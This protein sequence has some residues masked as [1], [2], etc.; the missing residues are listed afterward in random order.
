MDVA[1]GI[2]VYGTRV[3][4]YSI[5]SEI[6]FFQWTGTTWINQGTGITCAGSLNIDKLGRL[7][8]IGSDGFIYAWCADPNLQGHVV[9]VGVNGSLSAGTLAAGL[10]V[11][12]CGCLLFIEDH[13][14]NLRQQS[15]FNNSWREQG[16]IAEDIGG[17]LASDEKNERIFIKGV[18]SDNNI[19][20][21]NWDYNAVNISALKKLGK[22]CEAFYNDAKKYYW[23]IEAPDA[24]MVISTES[25]QLYYT[26]RNNRLW[27]FYNDMDKG[28]EPN[29]YSTPLHASGPANGALALEPGSLGSLFYVSSQK[30]CKIDWTKADYPIDCPKM[31]LPDGP[32]AGTDPDEPR[33]AQ[34]A[35][36]KTDNT[37]TVK[38]QIQD[39]NLDLSVTVFPNPSLGTFTFNIA[40]VN[41]DMGIQLKI[42]DLNG[43]IV[44]YIQRQVKPAKHNEIKWEAAGQGGGVYFYQL[45]LNNGSIFT[46]KLIKY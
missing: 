3:Y 44:D 16:I 39:V 11:H 20:G 24:N 28:K 35:T 1:G 30:L 31:L 12:S 21:Y 4:Y 17:S 41:Q 19:Y 29:W 15:W 42:E 32:D 25:A 22:T 13:E 9:A 23:L 7:F 10:I 27:Y 38:A 43:R 14:L 46:G 33:V 26:N 18:N 6:K 5:H 36:Y 45:M 34:V 40:G 2:T 37:D 8:F